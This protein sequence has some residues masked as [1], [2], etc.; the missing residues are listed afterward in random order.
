MSRR[1]LKL[2]S[3]VEPVPRGSIHYVATTSCNGTTL[4]WNAPT[5]QEL[6]RFTGHTA[7]WKTLPFLPTENIFSP[8]ATTA[9]LWDVDY[10]ATIATLCSRLHRDLT[11]EERAQYGI[12]D[13]TPTCP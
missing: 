6:R 9:R 12:T 13:G 2:E 1:T 7:P 10:H 11:E 5:G 3:R 4:L 8:V